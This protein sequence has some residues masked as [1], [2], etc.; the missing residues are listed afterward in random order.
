MNDVRLASPLVVRAILSA[1]R[2]G[3]GPRPR[4]PS[5]HDVE[6]IDAR[7]AARVRHFRESRTLSGHMRAVSAAFD[8]AR[9]ANDRIGGAR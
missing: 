7:A 5:L 2:L 3:P 6:V 1:Q 9:R 4:V 8:D